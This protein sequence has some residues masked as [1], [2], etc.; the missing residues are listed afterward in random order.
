[1]RFSQKKRDRGRLERSKR[2]KWRAHLSAPHA[3]L[4]VL[5][6]LPLLFLLFAP[7]PSSSSCHYRRAPVNQSLL[8]QWR[9]G[10]GHV[11]YVK[12]RERGDL[13]GVLVCQ[14]VCT[15]VCLWLN[16]CRAEQVARECGVAEAAGDGSCG[17]TWGLRPTLSNPPVTTGTEGEQ[18]RQ[19]KAQEG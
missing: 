9:V 16:D 3:L 8:I 6:P 1:M 17:D 5:P 19:S 15:N 18:R 10:R 11:T 14:Q 4:P 2:D 13:Q 12:R 7:G